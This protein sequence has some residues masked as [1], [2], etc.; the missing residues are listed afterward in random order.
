MLVSSTC[1]GF[2]KGY[3]AYGEGEVCI[4]DREY[5]KKEEFEN[6]DISF[7]LNSG[8]TGV[9]DGFF[10]IFAG[11]KEIIIPDTVTHIGVTDVT[12]GILRKNKALIR[13]TFDSYAEEFARKYGFE[14]L[15]SD[16]EIACVGDYFEYGADIITMCFSINGEPYIH[17]DSRC[18]GSSAGS[19]GG[20]EV[21]LSIPKDFYLTHNEKDIADM[22]WGS[23]YDKILNSTKLK[24]FLEKARSRNGYYLRNNEQAD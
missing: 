2:Y 8:V 20:G 15:H 9:E 1:Y 23:C 7:I 21:S 14:F 18:Q 24:V 16:I 6:K 5:Y 12:L 3:S 22:C 11:L 17:Q 10:D 13:G 4:K 19:T